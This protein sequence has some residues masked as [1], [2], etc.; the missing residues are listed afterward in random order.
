MTPRS[1][2]AD[3]ILTASESAEDIIPAQIAAFDRLE[4]R[5]NGTQG[6]LLVIPIRDAPKF[7]SLI[8]P[9]KFI[10]GPSLISALQFDLI[11]PVGVVFQSASLGPAAVLANKQASAAFQ[12]LEDKIAAGQDFTA[13]VD[14]I[15]ALNAQ[16]QAAIAVA[17]GKGV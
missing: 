16:I 13:E 11:L 10:A 6:G 1:A 3:S 4:A 12:R 7:S 15:N 9:V 8:I 14:Q 17:Q 2:L 5:V